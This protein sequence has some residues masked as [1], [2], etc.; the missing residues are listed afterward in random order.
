M[1]KYKVEMHMKRSA[2]I[3]IEVAR[4]E[5]Q[6]PEHLIDDEWARAI[7]EAEDYGEWQCDWWKVTEIKE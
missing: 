3:T 6:E 7:F 1:K 5:E 4:E 2:Y